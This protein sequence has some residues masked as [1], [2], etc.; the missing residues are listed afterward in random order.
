MIDTNVYLSHWPFRRLPL[1]ETDALVAKLRAAGIA[2]AWAG[3]FDGLLHKDVTAVNARL[4]D[5]CARH[6]D[7]LLPFGAINLA[8]PDWQGD[9]RRCRESHGMHGIRLH[10]NYH[11]YRLDDPRFGEL[12]TLAGQHR[13]IVQV[14]VRMEDDRTQHPL[15]RVPGVDLTNLA[16][17]LAAQ[18]QVQVQLLNSGRDVTP[19]LLRELAELPN[20]WLDFAMTE[21]VG[22]VA[23]LAG[24]FHMDRVL[25]GTYA[26]FFPVES[27]L[28]KLDE[29]EL[30]HTLRDRFTRKNAEQLTRLAGKKPGQ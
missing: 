29:S 16:N 25:L 26:P 8:L 9:V 30:G 14:V 20:V 4:A 1:D 5:E 15:V 17:V 13:L 6:A 11:G 23:Q 27:S 7:L 10:P 21:G 22:G 3:S 18:P 12:L 19:T 24:D 2:Q 28:L